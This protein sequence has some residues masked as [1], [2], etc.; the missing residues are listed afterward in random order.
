M[1]THPSC[2][3][4]MHVVIHVHGHFELS[5]IAIIVKYKEKDNIF[6][7][8]LSDLVPNSVGKVAVSDRRK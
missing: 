4:A 2:S 7:D 1:A 8:D 5:P 6:K 3:E